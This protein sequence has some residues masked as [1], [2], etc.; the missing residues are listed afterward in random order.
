MAIILTIPQ[1]LNLAKICEYLNIV[2]SNRNIA[3]KGGDLDA[4][5]ARLIYMER[6]GIQRQFDL[7]PSDPTLQKTAN[8]LFSLLRYE[9]EAQTIANNQAVGA[10]VI[11]G[12]TNQSVNVGANATFSVS[13]TG[14]PPFTYL[15]FLNGVIIPGATGSSYTKTN[16]QLSDSGGVYSVQVTD[17]ANRSVFSNTATLTV[18]A[19]LSVDYWYG[20]TDYSSDLNSG[21]DNVPYLGTFPYTAGQ[22]LSFTWPSGAAVNKYLVVRYPD[23]ESIKTQYGNAPLNNGLIPSIAFDNIV[24]FGGKRR[25][26]SRS[27]N[28]FS[29]NTAAPLIFS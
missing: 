23:T 15:W 19:T 18:T 8:Y 5:R 2:N 16:A 3:L 17:V 28:P 24:T 20:D 13:V 12:P 9:N 1:I 6:Y 4:K 22:P 27:G 14:A 11:T 10:P 26:F 25:I 21:I 29:M 7:N